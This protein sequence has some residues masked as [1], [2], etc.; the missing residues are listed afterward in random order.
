MEATPQ[1]RICSSQRVQLLPS[2]GGSGALG[3][4]G[5]SGALGGLG[6]SGALGGL[7]DTRGAGGLGGLRGTQ[8]AWGR[9]GGSGVLGGQG[10]SWSWW[11]GW[12][13]PPCRVGSSGPRLAS[14][15][16]GPLD[17]S[18][19]RNHSPTHPLPQGRVARQHVTEAWGGLVSQMPINGLGAS[20]GSNLGE[21]ISFLVTNCR[22][23]HPD[24]QRKALGQG[25][26]GVTSSANTG[27]GPLVCDGRGEGGV[28]EGERARRKNP[29]AED[30]ERPAGLLL[31]E[32]AVHLN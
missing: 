22:R 9:S 15:R 3:G 25:C 13:S 26:T 29:Y 8:G 30:P 31:N 7:R 10:I 4:L 12:A 2:L 6:G 20:C 24:T 17:E 14:A 11:T 21:S 16:K 1:S 32:G 19:H 27:Y 18:S 5:G 28:T 23:R